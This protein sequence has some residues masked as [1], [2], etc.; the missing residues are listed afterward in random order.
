VKYTTAA[1]SRAVLNRDRI[2]CRRGGGAE[3]RTSRD[4]YDTDHM[5]RYLTTDDYLIEAAHNPIMGAA[6]TT[7][8]WTQESHALLQRS[9]AEP[10]ADHWASTTES[11]VSTGR[12]SGKLLFEGG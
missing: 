10:S 4:G 5:T 3:V 12:A 8:G 7:P 9:A 2:Q 1:L 11:G 6:W